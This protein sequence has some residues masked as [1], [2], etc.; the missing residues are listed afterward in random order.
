MSQS[1][2]VKV[3]M[4]TACAILQWELA[5]MWGHVSV[6]TPDG[7]GFSLMPIRPRPYLSPPDDI[8]A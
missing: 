5:N 6:R 8:K 3:K 1:Q 7:N 2:E 4:S